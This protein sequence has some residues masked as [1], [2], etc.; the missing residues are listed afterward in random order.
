[1]SLAVIDYHNNKLKYIELDANKDCIRYIDLLAVKVAEVSDSLQKMG[2]FYDHLIRDKV[3]QSIHEN[4]KF[5]ARIHADCWDEVELLR[6]SQ[7]KTKQSQEV[8]IK[9][10]DTFLESHRN[11]LIK[12]TPEARDNMQ[13]KKEA[14]QRTEETFKTLY[15]G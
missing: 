1:M 3:V 13:M 5:D 8:Y 15:V 14:K 9:A 2:F 6:V 12:S 4:Q 11:Y 7:E 10:C